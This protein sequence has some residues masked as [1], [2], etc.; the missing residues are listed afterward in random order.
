M[1]YLAI[2]SFIQENEASAIVI[3]ILFTAQ[4]GTDK[5]L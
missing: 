4:F 2:C 1:K 3:A 5:L